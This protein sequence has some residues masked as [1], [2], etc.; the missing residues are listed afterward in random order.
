MDQKQNRQWGFTFA[1]SFA[2]LAKHVQPPI[3]LLRPV[4]AIPE[5]L[6]W[7]ALQ[8]HTG[9]SA[10]RSKERATR[11]SGGHGATF[12]RRIWSLPVPFRRFEASIPR[13]WRRHSG[14]GRHSERQ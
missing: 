5:T 3:A 14:L 13:L 8:C 10:K 7:R 11:R 1:R 6:R 2:T 4:F 9:N 12:F